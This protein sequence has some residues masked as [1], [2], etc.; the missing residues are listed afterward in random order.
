MIADICFAKLLSDVRIKSITTPAEL[1]SIPQNGACREFFFA[2]NLGIKLSSARPKIICLLAR[3]QA[4]I[5][6]ISTIEAIIDISR[7][8]FP[9]KI[10]CVASAEGALEL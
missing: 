10:Y 3:V 1:T 5:V 7:C 8:Q 4:L 2:K 6:P 9:P